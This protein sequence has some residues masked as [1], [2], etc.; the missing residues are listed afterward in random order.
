MSGSEWAAVVAAQVCLVLLVVLVVVIVRL[1]RAAP[2][3]AHRGGRLPGRGRARARGAPGSRARRR[4]RARPGR[5]HRHR[6]RAGRA[7]GSTPRRDL[8][9]R[10]F[11]NP[12]VKALAVG[13]GTRRAVQRLTGDKPDEAREARQAAGVLM[14]K[15]A[16]WLG[17]GFSLGVGTTVVA[18]RKA[19]Q[20]LDRYKADAVVER[21]T[22]TVSGKAST[23][24]DQVTAA[25]S[26]GREAAKTREEESARIGRGSATRPTSP[27]T[28]SRRAAT[29]DATATPGRIA[30]DRRY[31]L[32]RVPAA[33]RRR[34]ARCLPRLLRRRAATRRSRRRA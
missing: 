12:V 13:T 32:S 31:D 9:Y 34:A 1:E 19:R 18:A 22:T 4:L 26:E 16:T 23:F 6:R 20:Q 21:V 27:S 14:F 17:V 33:N 24:R 28:S 30:G 8:A 7:A 11:T 2:R 25:L 5:R 29:A 3:P 10:T 15:R